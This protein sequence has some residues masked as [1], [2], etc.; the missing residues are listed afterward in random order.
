MTGTL[1]GRIGI[2]PIFRDCAHLCQ[3]FN[4]VSM[5][6]DTLTGRMGVQPILG[7]C[8]VS[9]KVTKFHIMSL[10]LGTLNMQNACATHIAWLCPSL[11][12][13]LSKFN[14]ASVM[15]GR[16]GVF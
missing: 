8:A 7:D 12:K 6:R 4:I 15:M 14:I 3:S 9:V 2:Q 5:M 16:M 13:F 1:T 11:S 10:M